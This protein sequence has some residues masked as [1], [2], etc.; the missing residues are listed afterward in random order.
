MAA[1]DRTKVDD[2]VQQFEENPSSF[3]FYTALRLLEAAVPDAPGFGQSRRARQDPIRLGQQPY[4]NFAPSTLKAVDKGN[5]HRPARLYQNFHGIFGPNGPLPMHLTEYAMERQLS[6]HDETIVRFC[7]VFHHRLV[8]LFYRIWADA[9]P[10]VSE[11]HAGANHFDK[12]VGALAGVGMPGLDGH[13]WMPDEARRFHAGHLARQKHDA[14]GLLGILSQQLDIPVALEEFQPEWLE[15]PEESRLYLGRSRDSGCL[16]VNAV[17]G[18]K[19]FERQFRFALV[20]GPLS[21]SQYEALLPGRPTARRMTAI[22]NS[23]VGHELSWEYRMYVPGMDKPVA[24][25][26]K[27]GELGY[28]TW[29]HGLKTNDDGIDFFH[30]PSFESGLRE[31]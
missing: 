24:Q 14:E 10:A 5:Q 6:W 28:S 3:G 12:Y 26:G 19:S 8:S 9:Q 20:I 15:F 1:T 13:D 25:L 27:Y 22:V 17:I 16:G 2:L 18:E 29:L 21:R 11:D 7:D 23:Y 30:S 4:L 31:N